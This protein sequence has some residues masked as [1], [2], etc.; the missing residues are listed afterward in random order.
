MIRTRITE[1]FG[2]MHPIMLAGMN[3]ITEPQIVSAVS[4]AGGLG[5]FG[6]AR[7]NPEEARKNIKEI[8]TLTD[9]PFG[10]NQPLNA[11]WAEENIQVA[12]EEKVPVINYSMGRPWFVEQVHTYGGKVLASVALV[13][14][15]VRAQELGVDALVLIGNEAAAHGGS[16]ASMVF[17]PIVASR[18]KVPLIAAGSFFDGRGL[19]AAL[20]LGADAISMGT[21]FMLTKESIVHDSFKQ[22]CMKATEEDTVYSDVFNGIPGRVLVSEGAKAMM[23]ARNIPVLT[24]LRSA[25]AVK[26][27]LKLSTGQFIRS[28][29]KMMAGEGKRNL[30]QQALEA[31]GAMR[32]IRAIYDGDAKKGVLYVGQSVGAIDDLPTCKEVVECVAAQ[33]E[34][35]LRTAGVKPRS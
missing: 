15:A 13:R 12:V 2:I 33:A 21:R 3:W 17:I 25:L 35:V 34:E 27:M 23:N 5:V 31:T 8:R 24:W 30:F 10:V 32:F 7:C 22:L 20:C 6:M 16:I 11:P 19:A 29:L 14:H 4:N 18:T 9:S 1:L 28:S 26:R